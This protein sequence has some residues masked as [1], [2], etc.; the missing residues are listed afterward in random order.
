[1]LHQDIHSILLITLSNIGDAVMTTP[2]MTA[3]HNKYPRAVMD[4]V[5]DARSSELFS[6]C[7][8]RGEIFL[9]DK[10]AGWRGVL[11]LVKLLRAKRYDLVVDL[12]TDG[13]TLLLHARRRLTRRR[14][15][16]AGAHA[17]QRHFA[18]IGPREG[19]SDIPATCL[20]LSPHDREFAR[21]QLAV[22]PGTRWLALGPG[23]RWSAKRW[24]LAAFRALLDQLQT[25]F[26]AVIL[27]G[28]ADDAGSCQQLAAHTALPCL[29]LAGKTTLLQAA[30]V[31]QQASLF[32]GNDSGLGHLAAACDTATLTLFGPGDPARYH[33]WHP[34]ARWVQSDSGYIADVPVDEVAAAISGFHAPAWEPEEN[35]L[36]RKHT[37]KHGRKIPE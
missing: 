28:D 14:G 35:I 34:R 4:I 26:D 30:A 10:Q 32:I 25:A 2:V 13:L 20:W 9:K 23:A 7:P 21:R 3:L 5:A 11:G 1:M 8:Y 24:P 19:I 22:L 17:V 15:K 18:V 12:R 16:A 27:L 36:P 6:H 37:E 31:L 29:D 33:P